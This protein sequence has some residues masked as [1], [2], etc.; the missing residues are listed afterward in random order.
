MS[1]LLDTDTCSAHF[2]QLSKVTSRFL[3]SSGR[4]YVSV[5]TLG[6]LYSWVLRSKAPPSR[7][8]SLR[9]LLN[10]VTVLDVTQ[11]VARRFGEIRAYLLDK[12]QPMPTADQFIAA[13]ALVQNLTLVTHNTKDYVNVPGL[14]LDDWLVP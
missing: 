12:G 7:A 10:E 8:K 4:L 5:I 9:E 11:A 1:F 14:T 13:T 3:Q 6:E 2:R